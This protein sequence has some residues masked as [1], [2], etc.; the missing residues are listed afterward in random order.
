MTTLLLPTP[1]NRHHSRPEPSLLEL[2]LQNPD[3]VVPD[4]DAFS[5]HTQLSVLI[6]ADLVEPVVVAD[7]LVIGGESTPQIVNL[8]VFGSSL[9]PEPL[10]FFTKTL[11]L[12]DLRAGL[13]HDSLEFFD[14]IDVEDIERHR[15]RS[16]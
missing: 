4:V 3:L 8:T 6:A 15:Q 1:P 12:C 9:R 7:D 2:L 11:D 14:G 13:F 5:E 16:A 10:D